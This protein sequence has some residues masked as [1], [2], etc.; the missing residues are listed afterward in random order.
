MSLL[1]EL[2]TSVLRE[3]SMTDSIHRLE[4][5]GQA[6]STV[7]EVDMHLRLKVTLGADR[8]EAGREM[9]LVP[10]DWLEGEVVVALRNLEVIP[11]TLI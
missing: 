5:V 2:L 11:K 3:S 7:A 10:S 4:L 9:D 8:E 1:M 6:D